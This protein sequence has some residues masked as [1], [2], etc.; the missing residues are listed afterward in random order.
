M[1]FEDPVPDLS[2]KRRNGLQLGC[3]ACDRRDRILRFNWKLALEMPMGEFSAY[4]QTLVEKKT[5]KA[6][7]LFACPTCQ[8][9]WYLDGNREM[10]IL[11]PDGKMALLEE[12]GASLMQLPLG[13]IEKAREIGATP[14]HQLSGEK[15]YAE[16][17]CQALTSRGAWIDKCLLCFKATPPFETYSK[18]A[19][20]IK[21]IT[22]IR[23]SDYALPLEVR[24]ATC[25]SAQGRPGRALTR[26]VSTGGRSFS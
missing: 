22:D 21:D 5:L 24:I 12:W 11:V 19:L 16:V 18:H 26:V 2:S 14:A 8:K 13:L 4:T 7:F 25:K 1:P 3:P 6:G 15:N 10:M 9:P 23:P 20:L 17:P